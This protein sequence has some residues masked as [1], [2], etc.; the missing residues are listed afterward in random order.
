MTCCCSSRRPRD[1]PANTEVPK[2]DQIKSE[3]AQQLKLQ[4]EA[5]AVKTYV[6]KLRKGAEIKMYM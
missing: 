6:E 2:F 3:L 4:K 1:R 5:A